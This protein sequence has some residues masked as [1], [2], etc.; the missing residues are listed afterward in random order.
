[1]TR[2]LLAHR[3]FL[4]LVVTLLVTFAILAP[5]A[6]A[7]AELG[8][9]DIRLDGRPLSAATLLAHDTQQVLTWHVHYTG[10]GVVTGRTTVSGAL[11]RSYT[12]IV[13]D[14]TPSVTISTDINNLA[15]E[16]RIEVFVTDGHGLS[17]TET[18]VLPAGRDQ[19]RPEVSEI[20][21]AGRPLVDGM[22]FPA[23]SHQLLELTA[24]DPTTRPRNARL[25]MS[26]EYIGETFHSEGNRFWSD[27]VIPDG[28]LQL[29]VGVEDMVGNRWEAMYDL[30]GVQPAPEIVAPAEEPA[31]VPAP[32]PVLAPAPAAEATPGPG[33]V[34]P[35]AVDIAPVRGEEAVIASS[36]AAPAQ[37]VVAPAAAQDGATGG[38][39]APTRV[40]AA[41]DTTPPTLQMQVVRGA[42]GELQR[43]NRLV[44]RVR[45]SERSL[46]RLRIDRFGYMRSTLAFAP[47]W[48]TVTINL[49]DA[50]Q[51]G[52]ALN[53]AAP[54]EVVHLRVLVHG[55]D[56]FRNVSH[57]RW[58]Q[59]DVRA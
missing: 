25:T 38:G 28:R 3:T 10:E 4:P 44:L 41:R 40:H 33:D 22:E 8:I 16:T 11:W 36:G 52:R 37:S 56:Q 51:V 35:V 45:A 7:E 34:E 31:P 24:S 12:T 1:M 13:W 23:G 5:A 54:G 47:R 14:A 46:W 58:T 49:G 53:A 27:V 43:T 21:L 6:S 29:S 57:A 20:T 9:D 50:N 18:I 26:G 17:H 15:E 39:A 55:W 42:P 30:M 48:R 19:D 32:L 2:F 59:L